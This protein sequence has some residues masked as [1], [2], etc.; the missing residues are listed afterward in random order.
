L[1]KKDL[2]RYN[3]RAAAAIEEGRQAMAFMIPLL[4]AIVEDM[5]EETI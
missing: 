4:K 2:L 5:G 1:H 3:N